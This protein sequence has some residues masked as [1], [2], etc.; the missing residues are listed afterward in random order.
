MKVQTT[1]LNLALRKIRLHDVI[2]SCHQIAVC[3]TS[4]NKR[5][6]IIMQF[7]EALQVKWKYRGPRAVHWWLLLRFRYFLFLLSHHIDWQCRVEKTKKKFFGLIL[8]KVTEQK[9]EDNAKMPGWVSSESD[10]ICR[11]RFR[12]ENFYLRLARAEDCAADWKSENATKCRRPLKILEKVV[13]KEKSW[14]TWLAL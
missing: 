6:A 9:Q 1:N 11:W 14:K 4:E 3:T 5:I 7:C 10:K 13:G 12:S 8:S 2:Q